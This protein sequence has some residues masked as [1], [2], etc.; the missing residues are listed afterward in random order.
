MSLA[1]RDI[2]RDVL[3]EQG[4]AF[5]PE[6]QGE[7]FRL[8]V[9]LG[10]ETPQPLGG[11]GD[12][13]LN[14]VN[15][16]LELQPLVLDGS[17][18]ITG[19]D[20]EPDLAGPEGG[21]ITIARLEPAGSQGGPVGPAGPSPIDFANLELRTQELAQ[22]AEFGRAGTAGN[23]L[24]TI[25]GI[26]RDPF[27]IVPALSLFGAAGGGTRAPANALALTRGEGIAPEL[28]G[29]V[30]DLVRELT[31]FTGATP[32]NPNSGLPFTPG[33]MQFLRLVDQQQQAQPPVPGGIPS[34]QPTG[35]V[36]QILPTTTAA[37]KPLKQPAL[38]RPLTQ[39]RRASVNQ[40]VKGALTN[41][42]KR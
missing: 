32:I 27:S 19:Y 10:R 23:L 22:Q 1:P 38:V 2:V 37:V 16:P 35:V 40:T 41:G 5:L 21:F 29:V 24:N 33:E 36:D 8:P 28:G 17:L 11:Q 34:T 31:Q 25:L 14:S 7:A 9:N 20:T 4:P 26:Q 39:A 13:F 18:V 15:V 12:D 6:I 3:T 42:S 30:G